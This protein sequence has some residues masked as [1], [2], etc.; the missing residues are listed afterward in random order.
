MIKVTQ[1]TQ[2]NISK[3]T[4]RKHNNFWLELAIKQ[5]DILHEKNRT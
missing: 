5:Q 4:T 2:K 1:N 3:S